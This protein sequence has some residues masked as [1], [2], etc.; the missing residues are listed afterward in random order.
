MTD[1]APETEATPKPRKRSCLR[2][3]VKLFLWLLV[4]LFLALAGAGFFTYL[5]YD[6]VVSDGTPGA[7]VRVEIPEG[8]TGKVVGSIL[9]E[10]GLV[11]HEVFFRFAIRLDKKPGT[12]KHG[13][14]ELPKGLSPTQ[15]LH[16][17]YEG[18]NVTISEYKITVPEGLSLKQ[19]SELFGDPEGFIKAAS[20]PELIASL[21][22]KANTLEGF[23][24]PNTYFFDVEPAPEVMVA[25][26]L[27]EF[28]KQYA[29]LQSEFPEAASRD[30]MEV[31]TVASLVEEETKIDEERATVAAVVYNRLRKKMPLDMDSTLQ[32]ALEK[33]GQR[34]L[35]SDK[36]V[37]S[38]YNTYKYPGLPPGPIAGPGL[39]SLRAALNPAQVNYLYF[40]SNADGKSH[41]FSATLEEHNK[42]VARFRKEIAAQR[43]QLR[44][45]SGNAKQTTAP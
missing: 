21:G 15:L 26:M 28:R 43:R 34:L 38:P 39:A 24:M 35:D 45:E 29:V 42:A 11:D 40:V 33:Y 30:L 7:L 1:L 25:R 4:L 3:L 2:I 44:E 16:L 27:E 10:K 9:A 5:M 20:N 17:L 31:V 18:P 8:A 19:T 14:Y 23:L 41:T 12:I 32:Y 37:D 13:V 36:E 6:Y 22:I